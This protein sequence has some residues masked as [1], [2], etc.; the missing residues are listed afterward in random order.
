MHV[1]SKKYEAS[2]A[3]PSSNAPVLN[4]FDLWW[5]SLLPPLVKRVLPPW[6]ISAGLVTLMAFYTDDQVLT[7][8][9]VLFWASI[10]FTWAFRKFH[11]YIGR[12]RWIL[13]AYHAALSFLIV[14]PALAQVSGNAC[15]TSGLF[16]AVTNFVSQLFSSVTFGGVGGGTLSNLICQVV[17]FLTIALLLGFLGVLGYVAYQIGYQRQPISTVLDPLMGFLIF[18]GGASVIISVMIGSGGVVSV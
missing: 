6:Q 15:S 12:F 17:G 13:P 8:A 3:L 11:R 4:R 10:S 9:I 14:T 16:S 1:T 5:A 18:A 2:I 7:T